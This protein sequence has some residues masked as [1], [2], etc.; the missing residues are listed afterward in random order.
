ME[1]QPEQPTN[2]PV[3]EDDETPKPI[4]AEQFKAAFSELVDRAKAAGLRPAQIMLGAYVKQAFGMVDGLLGA[5]EGESPKKKPEA[6]V[7]AKPDVQA[8]AKTQENPS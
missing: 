2:K 4:N 5:L 7:E 6:K 8:E 1:P 3:I